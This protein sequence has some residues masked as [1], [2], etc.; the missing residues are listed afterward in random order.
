M[1]HIKFKSGIANSTIFL[2]ALNYNVL[3]ID[4]SGNAWLLHNLSKNAPTVLPNAND[5]NITDPISI[6][7]Q[8][9]NNDD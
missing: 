1:L 3:Q 4:G 8:K 6:K 7:L 2:Y 5:C 9:S